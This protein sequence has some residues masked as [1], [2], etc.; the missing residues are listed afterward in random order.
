MQRS[1]CMREV[2]DLPG[3]IQRAMMLAILL[4]SENK[5]CQHE[6]GKF[7]YFLS[8][9]D[10]TWCIFSAGQLTLL[11]EAQSLS[12]HRIAASNVPLL[13]KDNQYPVFWMRILPDTDQ[14]LNICCAAL[15]NADKHKQAHCPIC[16]V[17][18][19]TVHTVLPAH[20]ARLPCSTPC[21]G[22]WLYP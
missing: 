4:P 1:R 5:V 9:A 11:S 13:L 19:P 6:K 8:R 22:P 7:S 10:L 14:R 17:H 15:S 16:T 18:D 20:A 21:P 2:S 3:V 12:F